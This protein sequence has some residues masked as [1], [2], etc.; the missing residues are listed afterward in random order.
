MNH[1]IHPTAIVSPDAQLGEG[2]EIG[3]FCI[4]Q[5]NAVLG[6]GCILQSN[7]LI[8][9]N[10]ILGRENFV[11]HGVVLG[12]PPQ[13]K[14]FNEK[15]DTWLVV[16][17]RNA[18]REYCT[19]NRATGDG[20]KTLI[21]SGCLVMTQAHI[22]HNCRIGD[23]AILSNLATLAGHVTVEDWAILGGVVTIPQFTR[24]GK[25][26]FLGG[27]SGLRQ[28]LPPFFR[29]SGRPAG[30]VGVNQVG[31]TRR[32][33]PRENISAVKKAYRLLYRSQLGLDV[34]LAQVE[35]AY[36]EVPEIQIIVEFVRTSRNGIVRPGGRQE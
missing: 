14:K 30:P 28:D 12:T 5:G 24:V 3:P 16:G 35:E 36:G 9:R 13:D 27:F 31:M 18:F 15:S 4:V 21:G 7:V 23:E 17:D 29:G 8:D 33:I 25:G 1:K 22:G 34:A 10:T 2:V 32:G 19:V 11:G 26:S 6:D 20:E